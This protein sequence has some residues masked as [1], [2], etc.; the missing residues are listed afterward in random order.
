MDYLFLRR[1]KHTAVSERQK[2]LLFKAAERQWELRFADKAD[3]VREVDCILYKQI[4][5]HLEIKQVFL[6]PALS[7]KGLCALIETNQTYLS[8]M[9][10]RCFGCNLKT[11]VNTYRVEYAKELLRLGRCTVDELP[12]RCGFASKSAFYA[13]FSKLAGVSPLRFKLYG[14]GAEH[15][16]PAGYV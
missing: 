15:L 2:N 1:H 10:N 16:E 6:D 9:V 12:Q 13:A 7:L 4:L 11:L 8:N 14:Q 5:Y 3:E